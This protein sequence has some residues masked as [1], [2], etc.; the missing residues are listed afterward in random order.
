[1]T[2]ETVALIAMKSRRIF[3]PEAGLSRQILA[4]GSKLM[5][6]RHFMEKGWTGLRHSHP[7]EQLV[8]I[9]RGHIQFHGGDTTF[10]AR[11]GDS[12]VVPGG[13]EHQASAVEASEVLDI[14]TP[15]R[16]DYVEQVVR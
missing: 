5:L 9:V 10:E 7:H 3:S 2:A 12:F 16:E 8:Y 13:M 1:M 14:F 11:T 15:V 6:V 4:H